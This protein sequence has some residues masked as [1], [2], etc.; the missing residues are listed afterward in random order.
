M[1][2]LISTQIYAQDS[3]EKNLNINE[4]IL[5]RI[6]GLNTKIVDLER[7]V[8][9]GKESYTNSQ[10]LNDNKES[11]NLDDR[12]S[13]ERRLIE[14]EE[15]SRSIEGLI[16]EL[17]YVRT[18]VEKL[19]TQNSIL[20]SKLDVINS[21]NI[22]TENNIDNEK[23]VSEEVIEDY[24][25]YP[26][27]PS[28]NNNVDSNELNIITE[29]QDSSTVKVLAKINPDSGEDQIIKENLNTKPVKLDIITQKENTS[30]KKDNSIVSNDNPEEIYQRAYN[31]LSK[32]DIEAA[33]IAFKAFIKDYPDH[34]LTSNAYYW[35]GQTFYVRQYYQNA[36]TTF[37]EGY[38]KFPKGSKAAD[39]LFK[40][41]ISLDS[42]KKATEACATFKKLD[43]EFPD[44][45]SRISN[46]AQT[47]K[48]K[49]DCK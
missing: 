20:E 43:E 44:A 8:Y 24:P 37:A 33:R 30:T 48:D 36:A 39:Q 18:Q 23:F 41:A 46:R 45:P 7:K 9:Q 11:S 15:R 5:N 42:L 19:I 12:A 47:Y 2:V 29:D 22:A 28:K 17:N 16:E 34:N 25:I 14:L 3:N 31:I 6:E 1:N 32:G 10:N 26:G 40:L 35:L 21:K 13:H 38:L 49:L 27:M 4:T